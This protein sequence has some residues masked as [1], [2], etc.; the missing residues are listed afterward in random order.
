ME[1]S[2]E[3]MSRLE[4]WEK[5]YPLSLEQIKAIFERE[6]NKQK[7]LHPDKGEAL[8]EN[9]ARF[10]AYKEVKGSKFSSAK[11]MKGVVLAYAEEYDLTSNK[12]EFAKEMYQTNRKKAIDNGLTAADGTVLDNQKEF[13][14]GDENPNYGKP[15]EERWIR[16]YV[17][18]SRP[19]VDGDLKL[20]LGVA[21]DEK[22]LEVPKL[23]TPLEYRIIV[24]EDGENF[25][26][27]KTIKSTMFTETTM[28]ELP[29]VD[30]AAIYE[31]LQSAPAEVSPEL[32]DLMDWIDSHED[33]AQR[34]VV[35]VDVMYIR[36]EPMTN[37]NY[38]M[39]VTDD[40]LQMTGKDDVSAFVSKQLAS[41][42]DFGEGSRIMV[43]ARPSKS[44]YYD[45]ETKSVDATVKVPVLNVEGIW[46]NPEF[47]M[48]MDSY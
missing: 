36:D 10:F 15:L 8:W 48:P 12:R 3:T 6:Y 34:V 27:T 23:G 43:I 21:K 19:A 39:A 33:P 35:E 5:L 32:N 2:Q 1:I 17:A 9:R 46:V 42:M 13:P 24:D 44:N 25:R 28:E 45:R 37:G 41:M 20:E 47:R 4:K 11:T 18:L 29:V 22:A 31:L 14:W 30:E 38:F 40:S 7:D 26:K 16:N